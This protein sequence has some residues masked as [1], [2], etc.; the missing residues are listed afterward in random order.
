[1]KEF[2][3]LISQI[4]QTNSTND[5]VQLMVDYFKSHDAATN[6]WAIFILMG[7]QKKR[8]LTSARLRKVINQISD[9]PKWLMEECYSAVGDTAEMIALIAESLLAKDQEATD[10]DSKL[11]HELNHEFSRGFSHEYTL[12]E[13]MEDKLPPLAKLPESELAKQLEVWWRSF[14]QQQIFVLNKVLTGAMRIGVSELL[15]FKALSNALN[16]ERSLLATRLMGEFNPTAEFFESLSVKPTGDEAD[17]TRGLIPLPFC[18][19]SPIVNPSESLDDAKDWF[20]EW[21][22]DGIRAQ[23]HKQKDQV[24]IWSRGEERITQSFP[25]L[26]EALVDTDFSGVLDGEIVAGDW[27][28]PSPFQQLQVRL[29]K[30]NPNPKFISENKISFIAYDLL[31]DATEDIRMSTLLDRRKKL[32]EVVSLLPP[33]SFGL[34]KQIEGDNWTELAKEREAARLKGAEGFMLK[35]KSSPYVGGRKRGVWFK[36]KLEPLT[37][38][39]ILTAAQPGT[40]KRASLYTDYTFSIWKNKILVPIAKAYSGLNDTEIRS[41]DSWVRRN[42]QERFGPVRTLKPE[43]VFEIGFEGVAESRRHKSGYALRFPRILRERV[44]KDAVDANK[45]E[46]VAELL[47][48]VSKRES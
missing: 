8:I 24:E 12:V 4:D 41:L 48:F 20:V 15:V 16:V 35:K 2:A 21:K 9:V 3:S 43:K 45:V 11:D 14:S 10:K 18:L 42:T 7:K 46:D 30:K 1:M 27:A 28:V 19:A 25:D 26:V 33:L 17:P 23:I 29:N 34:S 22:W 36:W 5:K 13:W 47:K 38:D 6:A 44:D 31:A 39:A 37:I 32:K 40:G